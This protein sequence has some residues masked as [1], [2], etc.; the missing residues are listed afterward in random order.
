MMKIFAVMLD[1][2]ASVQANVVRHVRTQGTLRAIDWCNELHA[3]PDGFAAIAKKFA[4]S[5]LFQFPGRV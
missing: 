1:Q 3:G 2:L 4:T 5:L